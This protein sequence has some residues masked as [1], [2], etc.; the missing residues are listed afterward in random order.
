MGETTRYNSVGTGAGEIRFYRQFEPTGNALE[1][2]GIDTTTELLLTN[3]DTLTVGE[4]VLWHDNHHTGRARVGGYRYV[5]NSNVSTAGDVSIVN[6]I[7]YLR[8]KNSADKAFWK[9]KLI[10]GRR[11]RIWVSDSRYKEALLSSSVGELF[12]KL[13]ANVTNVKDVGAALTNNHNVSL[14]YRTNIP[15]YDDFADVAFSGKL[16]DLDGNPLGGL[17]STSGDY[18]IASAFFNYKVRLSQ[19]ATANATFTLPNSAGSVADESNAGQG[20]AVTIINDSA[21]TLTVAGN[22]PQKVDGVSSIDL[23]AGESAILIATGNPN[24]QWR[25][26]RNESYILTD[27]K[28]L[29]AIQSSRSSADRGKTFKVGSTDE[30]VIELVAESGGSGATKTK[31]GEFTSTTTAAVSNLVGATTPEIETAG[32]N[33]GWAVSGVYL[34]N[35]DVAFDGLKVDIYLDSTLEGSF[36]IPS[37][38]LDSS[39]N[40][41][42]APYIKLGSSSARVG[43]S[44]AY[45]A[46]EYYLTFVSAGTGAFPSGTKKAVIYTVDF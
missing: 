30:D 10:S 2:E 43:V 11:V 13:F 39:Y 29:D 33:A 21:Y 41:S 26:I 8:P 40:Q 34:K 17:Y 12:G 25:S 44:Y 4:F 5:T 35:P 3:G 45:V 9:S 7:L 23:A 36:F 24:S 28:I 42:D 27:E 14:D 20:W 37:G 18:A 19:T 31:I 16:E 15:T 22:G 46:N 38:R 32:T 6:N 1:S